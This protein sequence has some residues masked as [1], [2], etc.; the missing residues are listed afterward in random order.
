MRATAI[1]GIGVGFVFVLAGCASAPPTV[2]DADYGRLTPEQTGAIDSV[3]TELAAAQQE[4]DAAKLKIGEAKR[5]KELAAGDR[6]AAKA[7]QERV[8]RLVSAAEARGEAAEARAEYAEKLGEAREAALDAAQRRVDLAAAK[9]ELLK[10]QALEQAKIQPT[11]AYDDKAFYGR[12][13]EA[14]K[15]LDEAREKV[16]KAEQDASDGQRQYDE[17]MRKVPASA[18]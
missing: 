16:R 7:E 18:D 17:R 9:V 11:K 15:Q 8:K 14:Q 4:L 6:D 1:L 5:E 3:R 2:L 13:A 10:L 12:V